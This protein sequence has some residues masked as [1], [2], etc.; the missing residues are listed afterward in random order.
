M[1]FVNNSNNPFVI[2]GGQLKKRCGI[3]CDYT[4]CCIDDISEIDLINEVSFYIKED[5]GIVFC[6][7]LF[8]SHIIEYVDLSDKLLITH[9][10]DATLV[11]YQNNKAIFRYLSGQEWEVSNLKPKRWLAQNSMTEDVLPI[12]LGVTNNDIM[13]F[14]FS[15]IIKNKIIY[16][17]FGIKNNPKE[18]ELC[19]Y[20]V[21]VINEYSENN[22]RQEYY[23]SLAKSYFTVSPNGFGV[24]CHRHWEA[25]YFNCIPIVTR[26]TMTEFYSKLFP[27]VLI[28][29]WS[30]FNIEDYTIQLYK[31]LTNNFNRNLLDI[32]VYI[33][34]ISK[35]FEYDK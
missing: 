2:C 4:N 1:N 28:N 29:D 35:Q 5:N 16:K 8:L 17:N 15:N 9:N 27:M 3:I 18:R 25:L 33:N 11:S 13:E 12:P 10:T 32:D 7:P 26:N 24:D 21:P 31:E 23:R 20:H 30:C 34:L 14:D 19:D 22:N 6:N